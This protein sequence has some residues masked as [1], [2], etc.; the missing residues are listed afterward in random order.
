MALDYETYLLAASPPGFKLLSLQTLNGNAFGF[1]SDNASISSNTDCEKTDLNGTVPRIEKEKSTKSRKKESMLEDSRIFRARDK[2]V[3]QT[4]ISSWET[5]YT[6]DLDHCK[7]LQKL[8]LNSIP[9]A[10]KKKVSFA[11]DQGCDLTEVR[12]ANEPSDM[13]PVLRPDVLEKLEQSLSGELTCSNTDSTCTFLQTPPLMLS[14]INFQQPAADYLSFR[15]K[16]E[17]LGVSLENIMTHD[18]RV[19]GTVKV[20]NLAYVKTVHIRYTYD[21]WKTFKDE[22]TQHVIFTKTL[23]ETFSFE[24]DV[25]KV[26]Q[27]VLEFAVCYNADGKE[28]WDNNDGKNYKVICI[29]S[30]LEPSKDVCDHCNETIQNSEPRKNSLTDFSLWNQLEFKDESS[31][32]W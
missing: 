6:C 13:P 14:L 11:D 26:K 32:Y 5:V 18:C 10:S 27:A 24:F 29:S 9:K 31:P 2:K 1:N 20:K 4:R 21:D 22:S 3:D 16:V 8:E 17:R 19:A 15:G 23:Y 25:P 28:Y 7:C 30:M 12:I